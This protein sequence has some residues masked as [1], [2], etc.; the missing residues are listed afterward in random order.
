MLNERQRANLDI[1]ESNEAPR[2]ASPTRQDVSEADVTP[3]KIAPV[4]R[5]SAA[6]RAEDR[7]KAEKVRA[8]A[9][10]SALGD[11]SWV[12]QSKEVAM[13]VEKA[14]EVKKEEA[15]VTLKGS[16][17]FEIKTAR[18]APTRPALD[19]FSQIE[20][21]VEE[22]PPPRV[23]AARPKPAAPVE[24]AEPPVI[25]CAGG[26]SASRTTSDESRR[27]RMSPP[28]LYGPRTIAAG[29]ANT[30]AA[31]AT[32]PSR[33]RRE[34]R[35][36]GGD[37]GWVAVAESVEARVLLATTSQ[38]VRCTVVLRGGSSEVRRSLVTW[39][40]VET[41]GVDD[42]TAGFYRDALLRD[43]RHK[44]RARSAAGSDAI[45]AARPSL[46]AYSAVDSE[47]IE[48]DLMDACDGHV[49]ATQVE[50][51]IRGAAACSEGTLVFAAGAL[52]LRVAGRRVV[53]GALLASSGG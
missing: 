47:L 15:P 12:S 34:P 2:P 33:H 31:L 46:R 11:G 20:D 22:A 35:N 1:L 29:R 16:V 44:L 49:L 53:C 4:S 30:R 5:I 28:G 14:V 50:D 19:A 51:T 13:E 9:V 48:L 45:R 7:R 42:L 21:I 26:V 39:S 38:F 36:A 3:A 32:R 17:K 41:G 27:W 25:D 10:F 52:A 24:V 8:S 40:L 6:V 23:P 18:A 37:S 43:A